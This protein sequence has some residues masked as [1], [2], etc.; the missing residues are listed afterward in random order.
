MR[1]F[2]LAILGI[3]LIAI[4]RLTKIAFDDLALGGSFGIPGVISITQHQNHG[5]IANIPVPIPII[6]ALTVVALIAIAI[7][8]ARSIQK[9]TWT[10]AIGYT[11]LAAGAISNLFDRLMWGLV[12]DW[13]LIGGRSVINAADI[14]VAIGLLIVILN[15]PRAHTLDTKLETR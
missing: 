1:R 2:A 7:A 10:L 13:L 3:G 12:N 8:L 9:N 5:I 14:F 11:I 6:V 15:T 4:D